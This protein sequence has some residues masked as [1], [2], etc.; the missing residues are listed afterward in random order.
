L[1]TAVAA[2]MIGTLVPASD[3]AY[4]VTIIIGSDS[5]ECR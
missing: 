5:N 4:E 3:Q 1:L 2:I